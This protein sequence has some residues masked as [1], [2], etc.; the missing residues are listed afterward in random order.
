MQRGCQSAGNDIHAGFFIAADLGSHFFNGFDRTNHYNAAAW[1]DTFFGSRAR[2]VDSVF[3]QIVTFL[4][5]GF[6]VGT[7]AND[8]NA[9]GQLGQAF[10]E[11]LAVVI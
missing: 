4:H 10:L 2:C 8:G 7:G 9:A 6:G 1:Y 5:F 11:L 3:D